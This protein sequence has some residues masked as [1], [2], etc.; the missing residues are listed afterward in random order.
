M[1]I[2]IT[3][4]LLSSPLILLY[5]V[6]DSSAILID[7]KNCKIIIP[8]KSPPTVIRFNELMNVDLIVNGTQ[9][10]APHIKAKQ[11]FNK[12][13]SICLKITVANIDNPVYVK[14]ETNPGNN[15][16]EY[17]NSATTALGLYNKLSD[18]IASAR[19]SQAN[20]N[21]IKNSAKFQLK[22]VSEFKSNIIRQS[23]G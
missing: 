2:L 13:D 18:I 9:I 4:V 14:F 11:N 7:K 22:K 12:S 19:C 20:V 16:L 23:A 17:K 8:A 10:I 15:G 6:N 1:W 5:L 21:T 3:G